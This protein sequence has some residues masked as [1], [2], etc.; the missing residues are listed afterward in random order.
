MKYIFIDLETT[1]LYTDNNMQGLFS[2]KIMEIGIIITDETFNIIDEEGFVMEIGHNLYEMKS[3][4]NPYVTEMH[5]KNGLMES[6]TKS[7]KTI[8]Y[9]EQ[10]VIEYI[11][12]HT[13][14]TEL[15]IAGNSCT[16]DK[17][18]IDAQMPELASMLSYKI[19]DVSSF[20]LVAKTKGM[21]FEKNDYDLHRA[22]SDIRESINEMKFYWEHLIK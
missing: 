16:L 1:G 11:R 2:H 12:K 21:N 5:S 10:K 20:K 19:L 9:V 7:S 8:N 15:I 13:D 14:D 17:N 4:M 6:C 3:L 18:F 22:L